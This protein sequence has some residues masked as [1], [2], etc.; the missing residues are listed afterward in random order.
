METLKTAIL[1]LGGNLKSLH[2]SVFDTS[3]QS[4]AASLQAPF[5]KIVAEQCD[6]VDYINLNRQRVTG[7]LR[8]RVL[9]AFKAVVIA[10]IRLYASKEDTYEVTLRWVENHIL[11]NTDK[12]P[13][14]AAVHQFKEINDLPPCCPSCK[15]FLNAPEAL[16][17]LRKLTQF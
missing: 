8:G 1:E 14:E 5:R 4:L 17:A 11:L 6:S 15:Y 7:A 16:P 3:E 12:A 9:A 2:K 10:W 13:V